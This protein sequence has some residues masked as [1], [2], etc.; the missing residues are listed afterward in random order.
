MLSSYLSY[1]QLSCGS[2]LKKKPVLELSLRRAC[3]SSIRPSICMANTLRY[4]VAM[5][6][7]KKENTLMVALV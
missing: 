4:L 6:M 5:L 7:L 3:R 2:K 1:N